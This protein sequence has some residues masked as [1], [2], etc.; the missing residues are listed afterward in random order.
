MGKVGTG[1]AEPIDLLQRPK[2]LGLGAEPEAPED[3]TPPSHIVISGQ[4][5]LKILFSVTNNI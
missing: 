1:I 4:V 3:I 5:I 2:S